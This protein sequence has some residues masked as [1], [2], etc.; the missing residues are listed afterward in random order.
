M[1]TIP[2]QSSPPRRQSRK[3][4][5]WVLKES[6]VE[7]CRGHLS[8]HSALYNHSHP[9]TASSSTSF[10]LPDLQNL[11]L[12]DQWHPGALLVPAWHLPHP[13]TRM[14][15]LPPCPVLNAYAI[16]CL[17][18]PALKL[19]SLTLSTA[20]IG[21]MSPLPPRD[22]HNGDS[23]PRQNLTCHLEVH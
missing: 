4:S 7:Q 18:P 17:I 22:A 16:A 6:H 20:Y 5:G 3:L 13:H 21:R 11:H 19:A 12:V 2:Q 9:Y 23:Q 1:V 10:I 14:E 8:P 15:K